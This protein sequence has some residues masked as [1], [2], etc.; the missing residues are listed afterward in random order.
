MIIR[1]TSVKRCLRSPK[2]SG[3]IETGHGTRSTILRCSIRWADTSR[4]VP[5]TDLLTCMALPTVNK[6]VECSPRLGVA[7]VLT[8]TA[9]RPVALPLRRHRPDT[10]PTPA[11]PMHS[12][13]SDG[14]H[15]AQRPPS[16]PAI[17]PWPQEASL[18]LSLGSPPF[19]NMEAYT[20]S[21]FALLSCVPT[22]FVADLEIVLLKAPL[23]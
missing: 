6:V 13:L 19:L 23:T 1:V 17:A 18:F 9:P 21:S 14:I 20:G 7:L 12:P 11:E 4:H 15:F 8:P 2:I 22:P 16:T 10:H 3:L 5:F